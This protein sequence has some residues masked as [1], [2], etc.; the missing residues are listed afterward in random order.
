MYEV[1]EMKNETNPVNSLKSISLFVGT[2]Q[3]NAHCAHCAGR[4]HRKYA[5]PE[6]GVVD[7]AL[8]YNTLKRCHEMGARSLSLSSSGEPTLSP[9]AVTTVL[10][11]IHECKKEGIE[12]SPIN[13]YSNGIRIG[14]DK[15]FCDAYLPRWKEYGLTTIYVTVHDV[16][17]EKNAK[18]YG[19]ESYPSLEMV[20]SRIHQAG[21]L[22]RG[23]LILSRNTINTFGKFVSTV[24]Y[25]TKIGVDAISAWPIRDSDDKINIGLSP[26]ESEL[27]K[28]EEWVEQNQEDR[29]RVRLLRENSRS[30]YQ[31]GQKLTLFP[32]GIL[33]NTWCN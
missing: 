4:I 10:Q 6:D 25:L 3:C 33:S 13:I 28:M 9:L 7:R 18:I 27:N 16:D 32:D 11:L 26:L 8:I 2:G 5:P 17:K 19:V 29:V 31:T 1:N 30:A 23:N 21:L 22:M 20:V 14:T 12:Y 24:D 15:K